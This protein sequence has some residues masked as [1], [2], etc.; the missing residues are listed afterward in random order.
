MNNLDAT[1]FDPRILDLLAAS[2]NK[3]A[4]SAIDDDSEPVIVK[5]EVSMSPKPSKASKGRAKSE[6]SATICGK[7]TDARPAPT[8]AALAK[9]G[10]LDARGFLLTIRKAATREETIQA[11]AAYVGY[12]RSKDHGAQELAARM[13]ANAEL[14]ANV[15]PTN[16]STIGE[17]VVRNSHPST[18]AGMV[19]SSHGVNLPNHLAKQLACLEAKANAV[20]ESIA[21]HEIASANKDN[22]ISE[23]HYHTQLAMIDRARLATIREDIA[24]IHNAR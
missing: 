17:H 7:S 23:R 16:S 6:E 14:K 4:A 18:V 12:D 9:V 15:V 13:K 10:T 22:D 2:Y 21:D 1:T 5:V 24:R 8:V 20:G 11:I 19:V 3:R